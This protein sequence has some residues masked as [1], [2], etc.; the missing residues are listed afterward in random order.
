MK[1]CSLTDRIRHRE[2]AMMSTETDA[3]LGL[4]MVGPGVLEAIENPVSIA[5]IC[6]RAEGRI[7][8][9]RA[10]R[11]ADILASFYRIFFCLAGY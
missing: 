6:I 11:D 4:Y 10:G 7:D 9:G 1:R 2:T 5:S 3:L 8:V